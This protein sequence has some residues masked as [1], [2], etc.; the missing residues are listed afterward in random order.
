MERVYLDWN[1][2]AP[3]RS[4]AIEATTRAMREG[5]GNS[6]SL[7]EEGRSAASIAESAREALADWTRTRPGEW[8][9]TSGATESVH[10]AIHGCA[11]A[12]PERR[13][14]VS[15]RGEHSCVLGVL[16]DLESRGW[17]VVRLPLRADGAW[18]PD[19]VLRACDPEETA[20]ASLIWANN[21]TGAISDAGAVATELRRRKV[22]LHLDAVQCFGRIPVDLQAVPASFVSLSGHKFGAPKGIGAL[23]SRRGAPWVRWMQGGNQERSRRGGTVNAPGAAGLAAAARAAALEDWTE[24]VRMRDRLEAGILDRIP[25]SRI[26]SDGAARLPNTTCATLPGADSASLLDRLDA[27]G[28]A[29]ASGSACT[30]GRAEPSHVLTAMGLAPEDAHSTLRISL[31]T[32]TR[33]EEL[34]GFLPVLVE[35]TRAVRAAAGWISGGGPGPS[36]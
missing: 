26:V 31:G 35:E 12:R 36:R 22:P 11:G 8:I 19:E 6:S 24:I 25:D 2:T 4:E 10:S 14:I 18:D 33:G 23:F 9:L 27:R 1:A 34:E 30:T 16:S 28:Y 5:W 21:E 20:L 17:E 15:T 29:V 7:H 13:R 3:P 32:V